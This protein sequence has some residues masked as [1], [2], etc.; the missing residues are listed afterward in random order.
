MAL[1][2]KCGHVANAEIQLEDGSTVS[3][4]AIC[5]G[6]KDGADQVERECCGTDGLNGRKA[7]CVYS[8][9]RPGN[10]CRGE[11]D[12]NWDLPFFQYQPDQAYDAYYCG[13]WGWD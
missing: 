3:C 13:C 9:P 8:T 11:V 12:S 10:K 5:Y 4:C 6:L 1:L 2:M 7:R